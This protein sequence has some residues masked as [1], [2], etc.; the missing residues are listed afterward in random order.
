MRA[1]IEQLEENRARQLVGNVSHHHHRALSGE[2]GKVRVRRIGRDYAKVVGAEL[3]HRLE[4]IRISFDRDHLGAGGDEQSGEVTQARAELDHRVFWTQA[5]RVDNS[6]QRRLVVE[7]VL[8]PAR[9]GAKSPAAQNGGSGFH[10]A[11]HS[12]QAALAFKDGSERT[13]RRYASYPATAIIAPLSVHKSG[14]GTNSFR[15]R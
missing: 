10:L 2:R 8:S 3:A 14:G 11:A 7:K 13:P 6:L 15:S 1:L 5:G 9:L 12:L 4:Q